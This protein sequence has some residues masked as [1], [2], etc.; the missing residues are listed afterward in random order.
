[1]DTMLKCI[2][3]GEQIV[4]GATSGKTIASAKDVFIWGIDPDFGCRNL[5]VPGKTTPKTPVQ[6]YE[7]VGSG[8]LKTIFAGKDLNNLYLEQE[9][10]IAFVRGHK[11]WLCK[12][13]YATFFVNE[14]FVAIVCLSDNSEPHVS[15]ERL[16]RSNVSYSGPQRRRVVLPKRL[17]GLSLTL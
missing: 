10:I 5:N 11:K 12:G 17:S 2:S 6:V 3:D 7:V 15:Y 9:Q 14:L 16:S 1:M 13:G 4:I 8:D